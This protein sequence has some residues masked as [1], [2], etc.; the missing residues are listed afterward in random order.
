MAWTLASITIHPEDQSLRGV[1]EANYAIQDVL[2]A[3]AN[4]ISYFGSKSEVVQLE[5]ALFEDENSGT[6][7]TT[8]KNNTKNGTTSALAGDTGSL[9]NWKILRLE[10]RRKQALN[11]TN[12]VYICSAELVAQ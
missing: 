3:T 11:Q 6:G 10:Y 5:F 9:G 12:P 1:I 2:D 8:L 4:V 7:L